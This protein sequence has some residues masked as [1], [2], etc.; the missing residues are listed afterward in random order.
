MI[1]FKKSSVKYIHL[2]RKNLGLYTLHTHTL[3]PESWWKACKQCPACTP[4]WTALNPEYLLQPLQLV[5]DPMPTRATRVNRD[6][7][8][9]NLFIFCLA[10]FG[11]PR[12]FL[13]L[14]IS[15]L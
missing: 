7:R 8:S 5:T 15:F 3:M 10:L 9:K 6:V 14:S 13:N 1:N 2:V 4:L 12:N 11:V